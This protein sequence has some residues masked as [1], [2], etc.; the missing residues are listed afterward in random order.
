MLDEVFGLATLR[1]VI[2]MY[3]VEGMAAGAVNSP[4]GETEPSAGDTDHTTAVFE[5]PVTV[6]LYCWVWPE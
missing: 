5:D 4:E 6:A 2:V 3:C 1:A